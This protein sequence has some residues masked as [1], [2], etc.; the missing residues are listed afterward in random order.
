M[1]TLL[2]ATLMISFFLARGQSPITIVN[3]DMPSSN[4]TIRI[5]TSNT[6]ITSLLNDTGG[7]IVWDATFLV[8]NFQDVLSYKSPINTNIA[9]AF[10]FAGS[11]YATDDPNLSLGFVAGTDVFSFFTRNNTRFTNDGRGFTVNSIPIAQSYTSKDI[12][13]NFPVEYGRTDSCTF[14]SNTVNLLVATLT[15][16]GK[17][18]NIVD[19]WGEL[20][21]P[22][23]KFN[24]LRVKSVIQQT[25]SISVQGFGLPI[26]RNITEYKWLAKGQKIPVLEIITTA[27]QGGGQGTTTIKYKDV[28]RPVLFNGNARFTLNKSTFQSNS[29]DTCILTSSSRNSPKS[30]QWTITPANYIYTGGTNATSNRI[31]VFFTDTGKYT[32]TLRAIYNGG[33]DDTTRVN[34]I[35]VGNV[36]KANF[37]SSVTGQTYATVVNFYDSSTGNPMPTQWNWEFNPATVTFIGGTTSTSQQPKV[38]FNTFGNYSV[39]LT[40]TNAIG[41]NTIT[42]T[43]YIS[44]LRT[45]LFEAT[46]IANSISLT[47]NPASDKVEVN[48]EQYVIR[49]ISVS[50]V[51][52][53]N[54]NVQTQSTNPFQYT[55]TCT[56]LPAG[57]YFVKCV[58]DNGA[59]KIVRLII[60]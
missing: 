49:G 52:G 59:N 6:N 7:N 13:Y 54:L 15:T 45:S 47:P 2:T 3:A 60:R 34:V 32:V 25:D 16:K 40:V 23:G 44:L 21:T 46:K 58:F 20:T 22:F 31:K 57:L 53:K 4:D 18:Q 33:I 50:D 1:K 19:S 35:N 17:R 41:T 12:I 14:T 10:L 39:S 37:G 56:Q 5:S 9:Y 29:I 48:S 11:T 38:T 43:N 27:T 8:P 26:Q 42:K 51:T 55:F 30:Y 24:C 28:N 36:P